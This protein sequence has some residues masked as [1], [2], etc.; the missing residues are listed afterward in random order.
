[1]R[2][3]VGFFPRFRIVHKHR[4]SSLK[5]H[6]ESVENFVNS[7]MKSSLKP[8]ITLLNTFGLFFSQSGFFQKTLVFQGL[9]AI[10]VQKRQFCIGAIKS[11]KKKL[12][13][14]QYEISMGKITASFPQKLWIFLCMSCQ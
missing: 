3:I 5:F 14:D 13:Y 10:V 2:N 12:F 11:S 7:L 1:L 9:Q 4:L 6:T 8:V